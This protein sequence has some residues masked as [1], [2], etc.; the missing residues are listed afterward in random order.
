MGVFLVLTG[1]VIAIPLLAEIRDGERNLRELLSPALLSAGLLAAGGGLWLVP[2]ERETS[3]AV[4]G[5]ILALAGL[6][7][8][9]G[10]VVPAREVDVAPPPILAAGHTGL[11]G[12]T[13]S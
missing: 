9:P 4:A 2:P 12:Q 6:L 3:I 1:V 11:P 8:R 13:Q 10:E 5:V 7:L